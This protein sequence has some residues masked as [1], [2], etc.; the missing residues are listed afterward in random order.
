M[1]IGYIDSQDYSHC[2]L[3]VR[4]SSD[5]IAYEEISQIDSVDSGGLK[6]LIRT[7][8][9]LIYLQIDSIIMGDYSDKFIIVESEPII[10]HMLSEKNEEGKIQTRLLIGSGA[11]RL[12]YKNHLF[13]LMKLIDTYVICK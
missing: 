5:S 3:I 8:K 7:E 11:H 10:S 1:T 12:E 6:H 4:A 9:A 13:R 2:D